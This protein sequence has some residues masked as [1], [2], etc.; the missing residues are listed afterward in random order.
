[1]AGPIA[2]AMFPTQAKASSKGLPLR[3]AI[4]KTKKYDNAQKNISY[5]IDS[6]SQ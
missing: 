4:Y 5:R 3:G 1:M 6:Q 2:F